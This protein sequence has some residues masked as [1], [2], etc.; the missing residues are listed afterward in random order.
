M[1]NLTPIR[2]ICRHKRRTDSG[3]AENFPNPF[4][5]D[6]TEIGGF[7]NLHHPEGGLKESMEWAGNVYGADR[8]YYLVNGS[9]CGILSAICGSVSMEGLF[10]SRNCHKSAY[11]GVFSVT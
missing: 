8:T 7:D 4:S 11:H 2:F 6:I 3:F 10:M 9:S 5:M 1:G